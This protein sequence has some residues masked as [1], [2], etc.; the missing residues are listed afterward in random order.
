M[1][2]WMAIF[3]ALFDFASSP[4]L[5]IGISFIPA[6]IYQMVR[7]LQVLIVAIY[8]IIIFWR[9]YYRAHWT[10]LFLLT[11]GTLTVGYGGFE[12]GDSQLDVF[13]L[14]L[15]LLGTFITAGILIVEEFILRKY[16]T[17]PLWMIGWMGFFEFPTLAIIIVGLNFIP[18][19]NEKLCW[20]GYPEDAWFA[21]KQMA[22]N[23]FIILM[24]FSYIF[25]VGLYKALATYITKYTSAT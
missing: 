22:D 18:C 1:P 9:T 15:I 14:S 5:L 4:I 7:G 6:S 2:F 17:H 21:F 24:Q 3:P 25:A 10:G 20:Y 23:P 13:G 19:T 11:A 12:E 16:W 8:S